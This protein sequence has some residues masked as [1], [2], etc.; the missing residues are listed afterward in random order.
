MG[1]DTQTR[2]VFSKQFSRRFHGRRTAKLEA[3][4]ARAIRDISS[5][6]GLSLCG[7]MKTLQ[8]RESVS[9]C[10]HFLH[11]NIKCFQRLPS[12]CTFFSVCR[13]ALKTLLSADFFSCGLVFVLQFWLFV[14]GFLFLFICFFLFPSS[15]NFT[16][17]K[18]FGSFAFWQLRNGQEVANTEKDVSLLFQI[19]YRETAR[20][21][22]NLL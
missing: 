11:T 9:A 2:W 1:E 4:Y 22:R 21:I 19:P 8:A 20:V 13:R 3:S 5:T 14:F 7:V 17:S 10:N 18:G 12:V 15:I 6:W 16:Y